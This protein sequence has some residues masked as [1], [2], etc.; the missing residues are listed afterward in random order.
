MLCIK[1]LRMF[2]GSDRMALAY[3]Y[4]GLVS[5][6]P[7]EALGPRVLTDWE[8]V[9]ILE[10]HVRYQANGH[11][12]SAP[13]G[14]T[15][16][17]R[18]GFQESYQ[19]DETSRTRHAYFHFDIA[20]LPR[21]WP[22][23]KAWPVVRSKPVP[24]IAALFRHVMDRIF[25]HPEW[26]AE[27]PHA[28]DCRTV[29][30]LISLFIQEQITESGQYE[31]SRPEPVNKAVKLMREVIDETPQRTVRLEDLAGSA[32]CSQ[33]HLCRL[34]QQTFGHSP[35]QTLRL[36]RLQLS[37]TLVVRTNLPIKQIAKRCG[38]DDPLYFSRCFSRSFGKSPSD[39]RTGLKQGLPPPINPLPVDITPRVH[40]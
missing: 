2:A 28:E 8:F 26:P 11:R 14:S 10:G 38:F 35:M 18:P 5:Y 39:V 4:G 12:Y 15:I 34:F 16:L 17:A 36:L 1:E 27:P 37:L 31:R 3:M 7:G 9:L 22:D 6:G 40:W 25:M 21:D 13:P 20:E 30:T 24:V 19:W 29:E 32:G 33:K 23:P